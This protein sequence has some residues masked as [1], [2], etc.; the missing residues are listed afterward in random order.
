MRSTHLCREAQLLC[1]LFRRWNCSDI[2]ALANH[3][4]IKYTDFSITRRNDSLHVPHA[5]LL[6]CLNKSVLQVSTVSPFKLGFYEGTEMPH[7]YDS[8][9]SIYVPVGMKIE[10]TLRDTLYPDFAYHCFSF[11]SERFNNHPPIDVDEKYESKRD[12]DDA[13]IL[14]QGVVYRRWSVNIP[15]NQTVH[16]LSVKLRICSFS[17][18]FN[19][20]KNNRVFLNFRVRCPTLLGSRERWVTGGIVFDSESYREQLFALHHRAFPFTTEKR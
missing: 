9:T 4:E 2:E 17:G 5:A 19:E 15:L 20:E 12:F 18:E 16:T 14:L 3:R 11:S 6:M 10:L 1:E 8:L 7:I 13:H